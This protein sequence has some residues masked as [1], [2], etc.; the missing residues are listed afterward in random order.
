MWLFSKF[1]HEITI[2]L[3]GATLVLMVRALI[4]WVEIERYLAKKHPEK[5]PFPSYYP[6]GMVS[7]TEIVEL[8]QKYPDWYA[9]R[10]WWWWFRWGINKD[11]FP[12]ELQSD[13]K[14]MELLSRVKRYGLYAILSFLVMICMA[15][16]YLLQVIR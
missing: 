12:E 16:V 8:M 2:V 13:V 9:Q 3:M 4:S 11:N 15:L 1:Y 10:E 5:Y 14:L 6:R 7:K